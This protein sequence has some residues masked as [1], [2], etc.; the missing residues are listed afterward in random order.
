MTY[1]ARGSS[2]TRSR[3]VSTLTPSQR[4]SSLDHLVTQWM[5]TTNVCVGN[6]ANSAHDHATGSR[7]SPSTLKLQRSSGVRGVGPAES[8]GKSRV[9]YWPGGTRSAAP[10]SRR[11][12]RKPR[13]MKRSTMLPSFARLAPLARGPR[14]T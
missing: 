4:V 10:G 8:T 9:T 13:E 6:W 12:P 7:T 11:L 3:S 2:S 5:S 1:I 14:P